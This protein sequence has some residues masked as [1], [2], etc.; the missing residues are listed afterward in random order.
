MLKTWKH[1]VS[2]DWLEARDAVLTATD[3][4][5][6]AGYHKRASKANRE[7]GTIP[8]FQSLWAEK[9]SLRDHDPFSN[10]AAARGHIMESYA[11][12]AWNLQ[13]KST[14]EYYHWDDCIIRR[15]SVGFSPDAADV[16]QPAP[17]PYLD[18]DEVSG[19]MMDG[20]F[21]YYDIDIKSILEIKSFEPRKHFARCLE[22]KMK[23][24]EVLQVAAAMY[25]LP[26]IE[27]ARLVYYCP[28]API[29]MKVFEYTREELK[30]QIK[31]VEEIVECWNKTCEKLALVA[32][33]MDSMY[34]ED[35]IYED[36]LRMEED[37]YNIGG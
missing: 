19:V 5:K 26:S 34:T 1:K 29:S 27:I 15:G 13:K 17:V 9:H 8:E 16:M 37:I 28:G 24:E 32:G 20:D 3:I 33:D 14:Q 31:Q 25:V 2:E 6:L 30:D 23:H 18:V 4:C 36:W 7:A 12:D 21:N 10:G 22:D 35:D 11:V